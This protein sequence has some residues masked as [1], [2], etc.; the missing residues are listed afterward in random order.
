MEIFRSFSQYLRELIVLS[1]HS[2]TVFLLPYTM[3]FDVLLLTQS[4]LSFG[5]LLL[6]QSSLSFG[7]LL[8]TQSSLSFG[9]LLLTQS[10]LSF[11]VLLL[12]QSSLSQAKSCVASMA[13]P[14]IS[15]ADNSFGLIRVSYN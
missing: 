9:V 8:L 7:V 3:W 1:M 12:T 13:D 6:T 2:G 14:H 5:V 11:G 10:S 15:D 4:S